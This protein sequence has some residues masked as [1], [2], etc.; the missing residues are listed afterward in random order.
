[1]FLKLRNQVIVGNSMTLKLEI[2]V[3]ILIFQKLIKCKNLIRIKDILIYLTSAETN[4]NVQQYLILKHDTKIMHD[5]SFSEKTS[6]SGDILHSANSA[7]R[8]LPYQ[9][10]NTTF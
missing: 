10:S 4:V 1:M 7:I 3:E 9:Y 5:Q 2:K 6:R 8:H